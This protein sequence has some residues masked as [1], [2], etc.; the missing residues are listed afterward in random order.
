MRGFF[1]YGVAIVTREPCLAV[2]IARACPVYVGV[3]T[4]AR[5]RSLMC[6]FA[7]KCENLA[8]DARRRCVLGATGV[9]RSARQCGMNFTFH[10]RRRGTVALHALA[11]GQAQQRIEKARNQQPYSHRVSF[12]H[13]GSH[14][15]R[16][17]YVLMITACCDKLI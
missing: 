15:H 9:A 12:Q 8:F 5:G 11:V 4:L 1:M 14:P 7:S 6:R 17:N 2:G 3:T 16:E 10:R 13:Q